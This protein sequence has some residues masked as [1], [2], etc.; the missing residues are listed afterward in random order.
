MQIPKSPPPSSFDKWP[1][2]PAIH[3]LV[4]AAK[5]GEIGHGYI[6]FHQGICKENIRGYMEE[7]M[8]EDRDFLIVS[9]FP[10]STHDGEFITGFFVVALTQEELDHYVETGK[11]DNKN[12]R[13][14][15]GSLNQ[16]DTSGYLESLL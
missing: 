12:M 7:T 13:T 6:S 11:I 3:V 15:V 1:E 2:N 14:A 4:T 5:Q 16:I 10:K 9:K 8:D